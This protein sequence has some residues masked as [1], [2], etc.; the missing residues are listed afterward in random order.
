MINNYCHY[1]DLPS[2]EADRK[3]EVPKTITAV[4]IDH[5]IEMAWEGRSPFDTIKIHFGWNEQSVRDLM[6]KELKT[7]SYNR[8]IERVENCF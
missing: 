2:V 8:W 1:N 6:C 7:S 4:E 3:P 5:I